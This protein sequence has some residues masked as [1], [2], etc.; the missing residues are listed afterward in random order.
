M[1]WQKIIVS[2]RVQLSDSSRPRFYQPAA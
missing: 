2:G 1:S